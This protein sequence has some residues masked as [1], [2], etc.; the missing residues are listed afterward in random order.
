LKG[1]VEGGVTYSWLPITGLDNPATANPVAT[2]AQT[3]EYTVTVSSSNGCKGIGKVNIV[4]YQPLYIPSAFTPNADGTNDLWELK[5]LEV[6]PNPEVQI[7][8]RWGNVVFYSQ[9]NYTP[10][11]GTDSNKALPEG[12]YVYRIS[13][14]PDRPEFQYKGTFMLFR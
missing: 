1:L 12:M 6:Y 2:P 14:F 7:Y 8:N 4:V 9:G 10:F 3:Q 13:P 5:G 11:D